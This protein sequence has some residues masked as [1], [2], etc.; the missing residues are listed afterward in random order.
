MFILPV[1]ASKQSHWKQS[2]LCL[3]PYGWEN[4]ALGER[5]AYKGIMPGLV[6]VAPYMWYLI[7]LAQSSLLEGLNFSL[8]CSTFPII[9]KCI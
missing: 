1:A 4:E 9:L 3:F 8:E 6:K 2:L 7:H 5:L